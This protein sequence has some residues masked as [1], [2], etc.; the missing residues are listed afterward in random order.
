MNVCL[1]WVPTDCDTGTPICFPTLYAHMEHCM[2]SD[3]LRYY[4]L[5]FDEILPH[6]L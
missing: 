4:L 6:R 1:F 5:G 2:Y 3:F